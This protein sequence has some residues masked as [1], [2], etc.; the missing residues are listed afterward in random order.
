MDDTTPSRV[1]WFHLAPGRFVL[2]LL[3]VEVLLW[4][5]ERFG[6][7]GWH[8]GYAVLTGVATVGVAMVLMLGWFGLALVFRRRFQFSIRS[9]LVLVVV[10][11]LP[12]SWLATE[13]RAARR[14]TEAVTAIRTATDGPTKKT[15]LR[16]D[17]WRLPFAETVVY[18]YEIDDAGVQRWPSQLPGP[19]W[20][21]KLLGDDFFISARFI[22]AGGS[23]WSDAD[24]AQLEALPTLEVL[25]AGDG[26]TD[27]G[28]MHL[29][30]LVRLRHLYL[31]ETRITDAGL[32]HLENLRNLSVLRLSDTHITDAGIASLAKLH[33]LEAL[34][35]DNT[36]VGDA[37]LVHVKEWP[38]LGSLSLD[39]TQ[40]TDAGLA[41]LQGATEL[42]RLF[43]NDTNITDEGLRCLQGLRQLREIGIGRT[44]VTD[45]GLGHLQGLTRLS[46]LCLNNTAVGDG[47]MKYVI[48]M[49]NLENLP[50]EGTKVT[51]IGIEPLRGLIRLRDV[52]LD[53]TQVTDAGV[54]KL[55]QALLNCNI[56]R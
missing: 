18:D 31:T 53:R 25:V 50:L 14:Q 19:E 45:R 8:K 11:A 15:A 17:D 13:M 37:G 46:Y 7:L 40:I 39:G 5:S 38:K 12:L 51:D 21:R 36:Q 26:I 56:H 43:L 16:A 48:G 10:V 27:V 30:H 55:Q 47:G 1:R 2:A 52:W 54:K 9:L 20:L 22:W 41:Y 32:R 44:K 6:W 29:T 35:L 4:L 42:R 28:L 24:L 34:A 3:G 23:H 33:N 49:A